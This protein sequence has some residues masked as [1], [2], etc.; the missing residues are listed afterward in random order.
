MKKYLFMLV[1]IALALS[2]C[3][4]QSTQQ[5]SAPGAEPSPDADQPL[6]SASLIGAWKLTAYGPADSPT[7]AV[8]G[9]EAGLTFNKDGTITGTSGCN[10]LGGDYTVKG[11]E[12]TFGEFVSTLMACDEPIM[13]QEEAAHK[14]MTGA[15]SYKIEGDVLTITKDDMVLVLKHGTQ[16]AL[17]PSSGTLTGTWKLTSYR[18]SDVLSSAAA[19]AEA[20][21]TFNEDGTVTGTSGCNE[22][23]GTYT[24]E[25]DQITFKDILSTLMLCDPPLM[26]QEETMQQVLAD[27]ATYQIVD[28]NTL[29][30]TKDDRALI[31]ER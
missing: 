4:S 23:G 14:V 15:A 25:G 27:T 30:I 24:V 13:Q 29:R 17:A 28:N 19:N 20:N 16:G 18:I 31:L 1:T 9:V 5:S 6:P 7:P 22:F 11:N 8:E 2:A 10:G 26:D 21:L 12:I 3:S